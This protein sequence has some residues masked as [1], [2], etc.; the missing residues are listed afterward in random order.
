MGVELLRRQGAMIRCRYEANGTK[1]QI[2][3]LIQLGLSTYCPVLEP[4]L[5]RFYDAC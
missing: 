1:S 5:S 3:K 4:P 2:A